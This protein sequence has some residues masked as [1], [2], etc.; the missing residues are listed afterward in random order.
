M[1]LVQRMP[2]RG[3]PPIRPCDTMRVSAALQPLLTLRDLGLLELAAHYGTSMLSDSPDSLEF[4]LALSRLRAAQDQY[5]LALF[6][7]RRIAPRY[8]EFE[9]ADLPEEIWSLLY[10][11]EYLPLVKRYSRATAIDQHLVLGLIRQEAA[12][13]PRATSVANAR[14]LMQIL[15]QTV[16]RSRRGRARAARRLYDPAYNI[17]FGT[18]HLRGM[19]TNFG[20]NPE[21]ALAAYHAGESRVKAWLSKRT[22]Q[23]PAEFLETIPI[24]STRAYVE[25]VL[26]DAG[27]YRRFLD[28]SA[29]FAKCQ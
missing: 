19:L 9:F 4:R 10:P 14:G 21:Q 17:Q 5:A 27:I 2:R 24:P 23:E 29:Q 28:G 25:A 7:A 8:M 18:R 6:D 12:F 3:D 26:R 13:N 22:F 1:E 11:Q 16:S 15:P 20:G